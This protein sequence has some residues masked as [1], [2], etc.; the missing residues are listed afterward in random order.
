MSSFNS[1]KCDLCGKA[2]QDVE[3]GTKQGLL[4]FGG[5]K[6]VAKNAMEFTYE[7]ARRKGDLC[8]TCARALRDFIEARKMGNLK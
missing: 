2:L 1:I 8:L 6:P 4:Q 3:V 7:G 5:P